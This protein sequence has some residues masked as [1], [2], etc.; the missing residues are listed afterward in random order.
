[1]KAHTFKVTSTLS[2][3]ITSLILGFFAFGLQP[4][5]SDNHQK[6]DSYLTFHPPPALIFR[7]APTVADRGKLLLLKDA[8]KTSDDVDSETPDLTAGEEEIPLISYSNDTEGNASP[9]GLIDNS[10]QRPSVG[11]QSVLPPV[12][13]FQ[14]ATSPSSMINSTDQLIQIIEQDGL[15][16]QNYT[17]SAVQFIPPFSS[18]TTPLQ[19]RSKSSYRKVKK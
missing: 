15:K 17:S 13:P 3:F 2:V 1:M 19:I 18:D 11:Y 4:L 6:N 12:D 7:N 9:D 5:W 8:T 14:S 16:S 10:E